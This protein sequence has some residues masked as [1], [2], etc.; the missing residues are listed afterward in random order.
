M[1]TVTVDTAVYFAVFAK[2]RTAY[3]VIIYSVIEILFKNLK[4]NFN[5]LFVSFIK[6]IFFHIISQFCGTDNNHN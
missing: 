2:K 4:S 3:G 5:K 6:R 1:N